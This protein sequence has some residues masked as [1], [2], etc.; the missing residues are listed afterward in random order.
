MCLG[1]KTDQQQQDAG[2]PFLFERNVD[3]K[4]DLQLHLFGN[5]LETRLLEILEGLRPSST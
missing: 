3:S 4:A 5:K 2:I 1:R